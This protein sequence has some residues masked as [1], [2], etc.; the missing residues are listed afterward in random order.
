MIVLSDATRLSQKFD[1]DANRLAFDM[2]LKS[3]SRRM[4]PPST[5]QVPSPLSRRRPEAQEAEHAQLLLVVQE[6]DLIV[7]DTTSNSTSSLQNGTS[8]AYWHMKVIEKSSSGVGDVPENKSY[9]L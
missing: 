6:D 1:Q 4:P 3:F 5:L 2:E 9:E 7:P 8:T